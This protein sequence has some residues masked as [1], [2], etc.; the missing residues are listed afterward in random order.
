MAPEMLKNGKL[1]Y[2]LK[3]DIWALGCVLHELITGITLF[4]SGTDI[5]KSIL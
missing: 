5:R 2:N 1:S 3:V 4:D